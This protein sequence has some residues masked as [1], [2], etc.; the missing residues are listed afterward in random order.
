MSFFSPMSEIFVIAGN[1]ISTMD[2]FAERDP[3]P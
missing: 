1:M 3:A 2:I